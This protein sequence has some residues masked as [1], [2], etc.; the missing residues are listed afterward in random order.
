MICKNCGSQIDD[1][2]VICVHCGVPISTRPPKKKMP[3]V[4]RV[5]VALLTIVVT[6]FVTILVVAILSDGPAEVE[7]TSHPTTSNTQT[8]GTT[9]PTA[10]TEQV[11]LDS[12]T[13]K[14]TY[15]E[16]FEI[17]SYTGAFFL[18]LLVE[19]KTNKDILVLLDSASVNDEMLTV[20]TSVPNT[21]AVGKKSNAPYIF[22]YVNLSI[23]DLSEVED[24]SFEVV[25]YDNDA[26]EKIETSDM[27]TITP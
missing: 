8:A 12:D 24:I 6:F 23:S 26:Y 27:I 13:V 3:L 21:I 2:A 20:L 10:L 1:K 22:S 18:R 11:L 17:D 5:I 25:V 15:R 19:N 4:L 9:E 16:V 7:G 14:V